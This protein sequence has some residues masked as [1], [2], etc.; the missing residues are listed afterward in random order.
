MAGHRVSGA[1]A[2]GARFWARVAREVAAR[3]SLWP[4]TA[5]EVVLL[6]RPGWWRHAPFLPLPDPGYVRFRLETQYGSAAPADRMRSHDVVD[7]L[8]WCRDMAREA[9]RARPPR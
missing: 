3:P 7:Y 5:V 1:G 8:D 9:R 4:T 6:A 2:P